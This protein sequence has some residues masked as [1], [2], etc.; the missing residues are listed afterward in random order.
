MTTELQTQIDR[1]KAELRKSEEP[2]LRLMLIAI[3]ALEVIARPR[4]GGKIQMFAAQEA[5]RHIAD[6]WPDEL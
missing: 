5:L 6:Q 2:R 1:I 4:L 3:E